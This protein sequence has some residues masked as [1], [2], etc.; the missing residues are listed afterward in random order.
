MTSL[1]FPTEITCSVCS[2]FVTGC[3]WG[4][5]Y[6]R[7]AIFPVSPHLANFTM[8]NIRPVSLIEWESFS[9]KQTRGIFKR[10]DIWF[11]VSLYRTDDPL[12]FI[13]TMCT[14]MY[15][16]MY[17]IYLY[18]TEP[19]NVMHIERV[20]FGHYPKDTLKNGAERTQLVSWKFQRLSSMHC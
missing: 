17:E 5:W 2:G 20:H 19:K 11:K 16:A 15:R 4:V 18:S 6:R 3:Q 9:Y 14:V 10:C 1:S 13:C 7:E 8:I 12:I